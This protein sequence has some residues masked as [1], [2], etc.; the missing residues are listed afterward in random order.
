MFGALP[1]GADEQLR[2]PAPAPH[3][4]YLPDADLQSVVSKRIFF[5]FSTCGTL[6]RACVVYEYL[7]KNSHSEIFFHFAD[8]GSW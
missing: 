8:T 2:P 6:V 4:W 5:I 1:E 3:Y 7:M